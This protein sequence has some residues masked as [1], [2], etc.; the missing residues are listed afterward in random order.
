MIDYII[1]VALIALAGNAGQLMDLILNFSKNADDI[2]KS[3]GTHFDE[4][5]GV[6]TLFG[7]YLKSRSVG[8]FTT[9]FL[10]IIVSFF[11]NSEVVTVLFPT[12]E[13]RA[14]LFF[15]LG[16]GGQQAIRDFMTATS[17]KVLNRVNE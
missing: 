1:N 16:Y 11:G 10:I 7:F 8:L 15:F 9:T 5:T 13:G 14:I 2:R 17:R 3:P 4:S 12:L 6:F